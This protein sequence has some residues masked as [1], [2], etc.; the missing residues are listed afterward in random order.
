MTPNQAPNSALP[1]GQRNSLNRN[2]NNTRGNQVRPPRQD[3][4]GGPG[5][6]SLNEDGR[7]NDLIKIL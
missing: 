1:L 4:R 2:N 6:L 7:I 5:R 3:S